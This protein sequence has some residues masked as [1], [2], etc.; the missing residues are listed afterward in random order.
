MCSGR[1]PHKLLHSLSPELKIFHGDGL[2][3][4]DLDFYYPS[5]SNLTELAFQYMESQSIGDLVRHTPWLKKLVLGYNN[6][7]VGESSGVVHCSDISMLYVALE[8]VQPSTAW[9]H[10]LLPSLTKLELGTVNIPKLLVDSEGYDYFA[11]IQAF[12]NVL[13]RS[14]CAL[15]TVKLV[16]MKGEDAISIIALHPSIVDLSLAV[17]YHEY[18]ELK[19]IFVEMMFQKECTSILVPNLCSLSILVDLDCCNFDSD[20]DFDRLICHDIAELVDS[21]NRISVCESRG[22]AQL[23]QFALDSRVHASTLGES[24]RSHLPTIEILEKDIKEFCIEVS[25]VLFLHFDVY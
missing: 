12:S 19:K 21:R 22:I 11:D 25:F 14:N 15:Q 7:P 16:H 8:A 20:P 2:C 10:I 18:A 23:E 4:H 13:L 17:Y 9:E 1:V 6:P 24:V 5:F 3:E